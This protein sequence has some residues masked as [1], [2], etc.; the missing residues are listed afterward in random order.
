MGVVGPWEMV[1]GGFYP[2]IS[3]ICH[4]WVTPPNVASASNSVVKHRMFHDIQ[5]SVQPTQLHPRIQIYI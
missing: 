3:F 5:Y 2:K 1:E 4:E